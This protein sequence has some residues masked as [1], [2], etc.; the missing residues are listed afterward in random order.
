MELEFSKGSPES[1]QLQ[2]RARM[3]LEDPIGRRE[4]YFETDMEPW[5]QDEETTGGRRRT[6]RKL[7]YKKKTLRKRGKT[8]KKHKKRHFKRST[9]RC[10]K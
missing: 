8:N 7:H 10:R 3:I 5:G 4:E 9:K 2:E 6:H 1:R